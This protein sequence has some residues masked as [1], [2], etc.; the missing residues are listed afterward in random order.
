M[1]GPTPQQTELQDE[2]IQ[3][4]QQAQQMTAQQYANQQAIYGPMSTMFESIFAKGPNQEGFNA[5]T[6][7]TLNAQAVEGTAE[8]Y[9]SAA[10]AVGEEQAAEGGGN[11]PLPSGAQEEE[12]EQLAA[13]AAGSESQEETGI[14]EASENQGYQEW[15]AAG[16]GLQSIAAGENPLGFEN[17]ETSAGGA[18]DTEANAIAQEQDQWIG[19]VTGAVG[20][21]GAGWAAGGFKT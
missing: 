6:M 10:K 14:Q 18:A 2:Q 16:Q 15:I 17:A 11:N 3:A 13:S 20:A 8:N 12:K 9:S 21:V 1:C 5:Q 19:A 4:Y 7:N